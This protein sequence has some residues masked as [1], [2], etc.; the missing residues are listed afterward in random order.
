MVSNSSSPSTTVT[1]LSPGANTLTWTITDNA[2][3][4]S[5]SSNVTILNNTTSAYAGSDQT[6]CSSSAVLSALNPT[7]GTGVWSSKGAAVIS[8][9]TSARTLATGLVSGLN[10]F[11]CRRQFR[12]LEVVAGAY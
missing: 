8:N 7:F 5:S 1:N 6:V 10:I 2:S 12:S 3:G 9:P 11:T 4:C